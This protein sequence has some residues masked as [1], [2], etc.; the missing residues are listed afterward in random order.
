M[1]GKGQIC[2]D[3]KYPDLKQ[4]GGGGCSW[5]LPKGLKFQKWSRT[6]CNEADGGQSRFR[7]NLTVEALRYPSSAT[8]M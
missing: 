8:E 6:V 3:V 7:S 5:R 4:D 1:L 2:E